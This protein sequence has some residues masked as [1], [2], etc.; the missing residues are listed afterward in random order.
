[1]YANAKAPLLE[2]FTAAK[3]GGVK[4]IVLL[5]SMSVEINPDGL[6]GKMHGNVDAAI[7][8]AG[9]SYTFIRP[10]NFASNSRQFWAPSIQKTG[11]VW[12]TY[13]N[14]QSAPVSEEDMAAVALVAV[15]TD[16]LL[17]QAVGLSGTISIT[18]QE[19]VKAISRRR[20]SEGKK[21]VELIVLPAEEWKTFMNQHMPAE[22]VD[23]LIS[24]WRLADGKPELIQSPERITGKP[25]QSF[26]QWL[27]LNKDAFLKD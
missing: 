14:A 1:M 9:L 10:R 4:Y 7:R 8:E 22:F 16:K 17:N 27:E 23:Q 26:D 5:S 20:E 15:N 18:Q 6:L 24:F 12:I 3:N 25:S 19:Q 13:P 21:P 2:L 11:K